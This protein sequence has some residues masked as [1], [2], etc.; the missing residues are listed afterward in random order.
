MPLSMCVLNSV[1][2]GV[3][4]PISSKKTKIMAVVH[5]PSPSPCPPPRHVSL[6]L[7]EQP[8]AVVEEFE[9]LG[10]T[11]T[12]DCNLDREVN[13][14]ISKASQTFTLLNQVLWS[15]S[16]IKTSTKCASSRVW[17]CPL[18]YMTLRPGFHPPPPPS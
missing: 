15:R 18:C 9:C 2:S 1:C 8:E 3:G 7:G 4:L 6:K 16:N 13:M 5:S 12:K 14:H 10:S 11:I 17:S